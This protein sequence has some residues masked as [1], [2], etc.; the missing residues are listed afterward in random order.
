MLGVIFIWYSI[1]SAT[2]AERQELL[3]N[4]LN[5][6]PVWLLLSVVFGTLSHLSRAYRWKFMLEPLGYN[7][8]FANSF[9][10]VMAGYLANFGIP[11]SG[12][13]LRAA[14][15]TT[16]EKIPF[17]KAFG[18]I[19]SE[20]IADVVIMLG[21]MGFALLLQTELLLEYFND[22][23]INPFITIAVLVAL[24]I[25]GLIAL[26]FLKK[27][28]H[29][30]LIKIKKM[31]LGLVEGMR[32][33]FRMKQKW[34]FIFHTF[35]IWLMY[36]AMFIVIAFAVPEMTP[37]RL[38]MLMAAFVVGSLA[39][40]ATNGG[41]GVYPVAIGAILVLF[42]ISKQSGEAFGWLTWG[43]QT[44]VVLIFGALSFILLPIFNRPNK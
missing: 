29:P 34:A 43:V 24:V 35:F 37:P 20:R 19:I 23:N 27:S 3:D 17:E 1:K 44:L 12:E 31:A 10:A 42:G 32:S 38:G 5:A 13:V 15:L 14:T 16:Y 9:M 40:S 30:F 7:P 2:P 28:S 26:H 39:I 22:N 41:I 33:I 25:L 4:I 18:T 21:I 36:V 11:R 8:R 6:N